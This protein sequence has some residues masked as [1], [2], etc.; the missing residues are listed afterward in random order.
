MSLRVETRWLVLLVM[1]GAAACGSDT[2]T[3]PRNPADPDQAVFVTSDIEHF[4][5]AYDSGGSNGATAPFQT[6]YLDKASPGLADFIAS[7]NVTAS[8]LAG[9]VRTF[10]RYFADI[11]G[12]TLRLATDG[13]VQGRIRAGYRKI[14]D[15]YGPAVFPPVTFLIGRFS[16]G[17]TTSSNGMLVGLEF[18]AITATT[19]L[20]E[21]LQFQ[22]DNVRPLDSLPVI[23]AHEHTHILQGRAGG[24]AT[25][26]NKTLLEQS[27]MEGGADF[28]GYLVTGGNINARL[29]DYALPRE[30]ALW[31][32]FQV[33]MSGTDVSRW[34]YNQGS[35][36]A[37][38]PGDLGYFIGYRI[39][40]A[41]YA[42]TSDKRLALKAIIEVSNA[43]EFLAQ[44]GYDP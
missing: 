36:T 35:A 22:R 7:R 2:P 25:H 40:E 23:V 12:S 38:R 28:V 5:K 32:E 3:S 31:T 26:Q 6:E 8:S 1:A 42:R 41:Y 18:Y 13:V 43:T 29:R 30:H 10:P 15:M 21:L 16:T 37:D 44:S 39:A 24:I 33:A 17:G 19:P 14:R 34:L 20:D 27:L 11:R 9:M 4:W